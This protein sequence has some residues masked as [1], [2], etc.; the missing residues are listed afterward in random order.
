VKIEKRNFLKF[1][2]LLMILLGVDFLFLV[3]GN[4]YNCL[5]NFLIII[6]EY[7]ER[8]RKSIE[9]SRMAGRAWKIKINCTEE[10]DWIG[11]KYPFLCWLTY[12]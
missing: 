5:N 8:S 9:V 7:L 1:R 12:C 3:H 2:V 6:H 10:T 11:E 4:G